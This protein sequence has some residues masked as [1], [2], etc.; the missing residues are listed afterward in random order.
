MTNDNM[1]VARVRIVKWRA[2]ADAVRIEL[3]IYVLL[4]DFIPLENIFC[5]YWC[6]PN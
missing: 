2:S 5:K 1:H 6:D 3:L 4:F